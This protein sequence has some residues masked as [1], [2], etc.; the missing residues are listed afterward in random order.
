LVTVTG[1]VHTPAAEIEAVAGL[2]DHPPLIDVDPRAAAARIE[3]LPW[4]R[5]A[6]VSRLWPDG[7]RVAVVEETPLATVA[8]R[9]VG[10]AAA[11]WAVVDRAGRVLATEAAQPP[12]LV[13][14]VVARPPGRPGSDLGPV[15]SAG[16]T[17]AATLP[18]AFSAQVSAV[19]V[20][21]GGQVTLRM[22]TPVTILVG[23]AA[24]LPQK[25]E[26]AAAVLSGAK[27]VAGD[28]INV[29]VPEQTTVAEG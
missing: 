4:V 15:A 28:V 1:S 22:T 18:R 23:S 25:Y 20:G 26:D 5:S 7:V 13:P 21:R 6:V 14:L 11:R 3:R 17:V 10:H 27:L 16:L 8:E 29:S 9:P 2:S 12:G 19:E 24:Q